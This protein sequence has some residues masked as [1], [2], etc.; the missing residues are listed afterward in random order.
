MTVP[1]PV[2]GARAVEDAELVELVKSMSTISI[3]DVPGSLHGTA[4]PPMEFMVI[5]LARE[6]VAL[7][8]RVAALE[9]AAKDGGR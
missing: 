9:L 2:I 1:S 5:A 3:S 4:V 8:R 6:L 7:R